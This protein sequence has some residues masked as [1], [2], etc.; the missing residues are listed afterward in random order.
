MNRLT[1]QDSEGSET[2]LYE[3]LMG[4]TGHCTLTQTHG[5][6]NTKSEPHCTP[7]TLGDHDESRRVYQ[8]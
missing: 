4:D 6:C 1:T 8:A 2:P 3:T 5:M 7:Q